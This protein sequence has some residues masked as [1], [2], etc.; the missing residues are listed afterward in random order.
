MI[1]FYLILSLFFS[2]PFIWMAIAF[3]S[4]VFWLLSLGAMICGLIW[5]EKTRFMRVQKA[6]YA[7]PALEDSIITAA[8]KRVQVRTGAEN[9]KLELW[10]YPSPDRLTFFWIKKRNHGVCF[11]SQGMVSVIREE[12]LFQL[13]QEFYQ[14]NPKKIIF[15]NH[16]YAL[17]LWW[18]ALKGSEKHFRY[19]F[20]TF[21][22]YPFERALNKIK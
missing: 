19:W 11:M 6:V 1:I 2:F 18:K 4:P 7:S 8:W 10:V 12:E 15:L 17:N 21:W 9:I 5:F 13:F 16:L 22:L 20:L 3:H 14:E